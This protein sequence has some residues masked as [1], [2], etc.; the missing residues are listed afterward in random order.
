VLLSTVI[1]VLREVLEA[2]LLFSLL[3]ALSKRLNISLGWV[4]FALLAGFFGAGL[5][6]F[7]I[8]RISALYDG[9]GQELLNASMQYAL[10]A[11]LWTIALAATLRIRG[12]GV[13]ASILSVLMICSVTLAVSREGSEIMI[14]LSGFL[15]MKDQ[16]IAV[17]TGSAIGAGIGVSVGAVFYFALI[18]LRPGLVAGV[19]S[20][21]HA[22]V[23][24]GVALPA[25]ELRIQCDWLPGHFPLWDT[26]ALLSE[27]SVAGQLLYALIGYEA[28]PTALELGAYITAVILIMGAIFIATR[29]PRTRAA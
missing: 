8:D 6:G 13:S 23:A 11:L 27:Q 19:G 12:I 2:A 14:Y 16:W 25:S 10:F 7:N 5:V 4:P 1:L 26:S 21:L 28:T 9:V 18:M 17:L 3:I 22:L 20:L 29:W 15:Q 24:A